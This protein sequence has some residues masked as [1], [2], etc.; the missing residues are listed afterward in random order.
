MNNYFA[1]IYSTDHLKHKLLGATYLFSTSS[2]KDLW[3]GWFKTAEG[4]RIRLLFSASVA[5][6]ALFTDRDRPPPRQNKLRFFESLHGSVVT[7]ITLAKGDRLM[8]IHLGTGPRLLFQLYGQQ[9]NLMVVENEAIVDAFRNPGTLTGTDPPE[10][11]APLVER[12]GPPGGNSPKSAILH[13]EPRF[14]RHLVDPIIR[15]YR[16]DMHSASKVAEVTRMLVKAMRERPQFRVLESGHLCLIPEDLLPAGELRIFEEINEAVRFTFYR[17]SRNRHL[18]RLK[19]SIEPSLKR[20]LKRTRQELKRIE[21][22][23]KDLEKVE[24]WEENGHLLMANAHRTTA[25]D[26]REIVV[27]DL[28]NDNRPRTIRIKPALSLAANAQVW[29]DRAGSARKRALE[30]KKRTEKVELRIERLAGA[31]EELEQIGHV[32]DFEQ[33]E[34]QYRD[35]IGHHGGKGKE[36]TLPFRTSTYRGYEVWTGKNAK[37]NDR[38]TRMAHKEDLWM[39]ARGASGAHVILRME[40][41]R[42][43]PPSDVIYAV[44][45]H[46]A[47][48]SKQR[49]AGLVPVIITKKKYVT[50]PKG[51]PAGAVRVQQERVELVEPANLEQE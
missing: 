23:I 50:K 49:G 44:A 45:A 35:L 42:T 8:T 36:E 22:S 15:H 20:T 12:S 29:Y 34:K 9:A 28:Y 21:I 7:G 33:W 46:T 43:D 1:L 47:W 25:P 40:G 38:L 13:T 10:P 18:S 19:S 16:L 24:K 37:S 31:F 32:S 41:R 27:D 14:P 6:T 30:A 51:A 11:R 26:C 3:E 2:R 17:A 48:N 4:D 5:E 39:H